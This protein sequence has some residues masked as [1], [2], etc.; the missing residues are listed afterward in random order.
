MYLGKYMK[1]L[2]MSD[3]VQ[4]EERLYVECWILSYLKFIMRKTLAGFM[5]KRAGRKCLSY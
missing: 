5:R 4:E 1:R 3:Q 2:G